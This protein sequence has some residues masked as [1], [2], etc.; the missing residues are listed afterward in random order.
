MIKK[1]LK[2][3]VVEVVYGISVFAILYFIIFPAKL[4]KKIVSIYF[5]FAQFQIKA[6]QT[7]AFVLLIH[8]LMIPENANY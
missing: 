5:L 1:Q 6:M 7:F 3:V 8:L 2:E 4:A